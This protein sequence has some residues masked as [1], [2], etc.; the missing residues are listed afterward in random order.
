MWRRLL[1]LLVGISMLGSALAI[2]AAT[3]APAPAAAATTSGPLHTNGNDG[4]IYDAANQPVRLVGF[5]WTG[6]ENGGRADYQKIPDSCGDVWTTPADGLGDLPFDYDNSYQVIVDLGYNVLRLPISWHNLEPVA[7]VWDAGAGAY[8]HTWNQAYLSDLKSMVTKAHAVGLMVIL[9]MHQDYWSPALHNI[10]NWDGGRGYCEGVGMP[11]WL[12]P[13]ADGKTATT[14][15]TDFANSMNWFYRNVHDPL[16]TTTRATPWQ[17]FSSAWDQLAFQFSPASG[18]PDS[19]AVVGADILNEPY[20]SYVGANPPAGQTVLQAAGSRLQTFYE[21]IAPTI[22]SRRPSWLLIFEDSTGGYNAANPSARE[23]PTMTGKPTVSGNW[24]YSIH[25]YNFEYG[26]FSDGVVRH[27]DFGITLANVVLANAN[28][29]KV[30]LYIGEFTTFSLGVDSRQLTN[31]SMAQTKAFLAWAKQNNVSWTFWAYVNPYWPMTFL[32]YQTNQPIPVVRDA[33]ATGLDT[34]G[35][36]APGAPTD[37][38]ATAGVGNATVAFTP[39]ANDG[40]SPI[41]GYT[42][43]SNP[44]D[45]TASG[46]GSPI[47]VTGLTNGVSYTFT[48]RGTNGTGTSPPSVPSNSVTPSATHPSF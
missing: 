22:T 21:T 28:T 14:Q 12:Y 35:Q 11:R 41:T 5:N 39:P 8:V 36:S 47:T 34:S 24:V 19:D 17:L 10:T 25:D 42:V 46:T 45:I 13:T 15:N 37:V 30:P 40:G 44:G 32:N 27:D 18:Y 2:G 26:T 43:T 16:A 6:T 33:L 31:A 4:R 9:D 7:P 29:W 1:V 20:W 38:T 48:V 3:V 23:T